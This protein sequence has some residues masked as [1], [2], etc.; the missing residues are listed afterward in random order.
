MFCRFAYQKWGM[1]HSYDNSFDQAELAM[2][3]THTMFCSIR[4]NK[5]WQGKNAEMG[6]CWKYLE[7]KTKCDHFRRSESF[8]VDWDYQ[9]CRGC[10]PWLQVAMSS[11][12]DSKSPM[13]GQWNSSSLHGN[14]KT[15]KNHCSSDA[16]HLY[17][18]QIT[19]LS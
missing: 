12:W 8:S 14:K 18:V 5:P 4:N 19:W 3:K 11:F 9:R 17:P 6:A 13:T 7:S 15:T 16:T 1:F 2:E 10:L